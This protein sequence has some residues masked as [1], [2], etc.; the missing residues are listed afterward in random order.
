MVVEIW[1]SAG[2]V[3]VAVLVLGVV[4]PEVVSGVSVVTVGMLVDAVVGA[5][6]MV[7]GVVMLLL[8]GAV[9]AVVVLV[10]VVVMVVVIL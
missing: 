8:M 9:D 10:V 2:V 7:G 4:A 1:V 3:V 6:V 5:V